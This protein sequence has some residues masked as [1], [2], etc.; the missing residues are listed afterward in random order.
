MLSTYFKIGWRNVT[1]HRFYALVNVAGLAVG[2][3]FV[4]LIA[5]Y[6]W[7]ELQV[8]RQ[9]RNAEEQYIIQSSW[10]DP[11]MGM[12]LTALAPLAR[13]LKEEYPQLVKNYYR[14]DGI[15]ATVSI[16]DKK[17]RESTQ[18]G[19]STLL[20]MYG[21]ETLSGD[22]ATALDK[23]FSVVITEAK[24]LKYFGRTDVAGQALTIDNFSGEK[25]AFTVTAVL[26]ETGKNSVTSVND[27]NSNEVFLPLSAAG[28][29]G[30]AQMESWHNHSIVGYV[31]LQPGASLEALNR[32]AMQTIRAHAP[33]EVAANLTPRFVPLQDFY[34]DAD[35]GL[36]RKMLYMLSGIAFFILLMALINFVNIAVSRSAARMKEI[37]VRKTLGGTRKQLI[38]QFLVESTLLSFI[39]SLAALG[40][41]AL[42]SPYFGE[43]LGR[44]LPE[45][46]TMPV[47]FIPVL[48]ALPLVIGLL[49]GFYPAL[50]LS[51]FRSPDLL[52]GKLKTVS[53][54]FTLRKALVG[55]QFLTATIVF[56]GGLIISQQVALF[57]SDDLGYEKDRVVSLAAPR[58]WTPAGVQR[59]ETVR[60]ELA[61]LPQVEQA[62]VSYVIPNGNAG[63]SFPVYRQGTDSTQA[64]ASLHLEADRHYAATYGIPL[65]AGSFWA[66][67]EQADQVVVNE[68]VVRALGFADAQ[69]AIGQRL[70]I[71]NNPQT[72]S[73]CGVTKDFHFSTMKE[74][75]RPVTFFNLQASNYYRF[76]SVKLRPGELSGAVAALQ[77]KWSQLLPGA[78]FEYKFMD[79]T[80][81]NLY[82]AELRLEKA[83]FAGIV[84][85]GV[86][87]LLG[88]L[89]LVS[90]SL[91]NR[92]REI[93]IR[94]VLGAGVAGIVG[95]FVK[96][97]LPVA[98]LAA[99]VAC[100]LGYYLMDSWL[101]D[102]AYRVA[103]TPQP[104][105]V[106]VL[107]LGAMTVL[108]IGLATVKAALANPAKSIRT[109]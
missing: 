68:S 27:A 58:D 51:G 93:G 26:R 87:V 34:L 37:G 6:V 44:K 13:A 57:F 40:L 23:P 100:P 104:F 76:I 25:H 99:L 98:L 90:I 91:Q 108:L 62:T 106:A 36:I 19:D 41:Y 3:A 94:K 75:I 83:A 82:R 45:I 28:F 70:R 56:I 52:K 59:M 14:W 11:N 67:G 54:K 32:A 96:E 5:A 9:L 60:K 47:T 50:V 29:F 38:T 102:Y 74:D 103:I 42:L 71:H 72:F 33:A 79:E 73:I 7:Q 43:V 65:V 8:N 2:I 12:E 49:A 39:A 66:N 20:S 31:E 10:K 80:L 105:L 4:L 84:L 78:V 85:M 92:T 30:R 95:L 109:D 97:L 88:V 81:A 89:G 1:R 69:S 17:F 86:V 46:S 77:G 24:A 18:I 22:A 15:T 53:E 21:F 101:S 35:R 64:I 61:T 63:G 16:G 107:T 55:F 48:I